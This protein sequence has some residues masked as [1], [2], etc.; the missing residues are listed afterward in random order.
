MT[1]FSQEP[2]QKVSQKPREPSSC[3]EY[4]GFWHNHSA[5]TKTVIRLKLIACDVSEITQNKLG[6]LRA[7][8]NYHRSFFTMV[9]ECGILIKKEQT[10][11]NLF[12]DISSR[13]QQ[14]C[15][16]NYHLSTICKYF[17]NIY[18]PAFLC[19]LFLH[20]MWFFFYR[21]GMINLLLVKMLS[22]LF[23]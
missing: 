5:Q 20:W 23:L 4:S 3:Q 18:I 7:I 13:K 22:M 12:D 6:F 17:Y 15:H 11:L 8:S 9:F 2:A 14:K 19:S 21:H 16:S 10:F 1:L